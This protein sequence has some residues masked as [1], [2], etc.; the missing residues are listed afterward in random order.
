[1]SEEQCFELLRQLLAF[2]RGQI[3]RHYAAALVLKGMSKTNPELEGD[4]DFI[5]LAGAVCRDS[6]GDEEALAIIRRK[7]C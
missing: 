7:T 3:C 4:P 5:A 1:M 2:P 6:E